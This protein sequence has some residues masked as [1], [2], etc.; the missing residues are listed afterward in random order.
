MT[1]SNNT[2]VY[3]NFFF[4]KLNFFQYFILDLIVQIIVI[5]HGID[6]IFVEEIIL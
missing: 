5:T 1:E 4:N 2:I 6:A 3:L